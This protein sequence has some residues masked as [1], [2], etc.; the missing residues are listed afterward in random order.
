[1][2]GIKDVAKRAGVSISTVSNVLNQTKYVSPELVKRVEDAVQEL[3]YEVDPIARSM[4]SNKSGTIGVIV[5][6]MCGVF[7]PYVVKG[8][9][10][11]AVEKGYQIIIG[12][13]QGVYGDV[14]AARREKELFKRL[15]ASRVDGILFVTM[16]HQ[17]LMEKHFNEILSRSSQSKRIPL[18]SLERDLTSI[19]IDSVYFDSY[20]NA[21]MA[22]QHLIDCGCRKIGHIT[23][24]TTLQIA[25]DRIQGYKDC[26][27][28]NHLP[29]DWTRQIE[30]GDYTHQSGYL[31]VKKLLEDMPDL[32]G[33]FCSNDQMAVGALK[34]LKE[35]GKRVPEDIKVMGYDDVFLSSI[36]EPSLSTIHIQKTHTGIKAAQMLFERIEQP[37]KNKEPV[38]LKMSARLVVRKSTVADTSEEWIFVDW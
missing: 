5:E 7:Y 29:A 28:E 23:G 32:D 11:V 36:I 16:I 15:F 21:K 22:V 12:D 2:S 34:L 10:S 33:V 13:A 24:P 26:I 37:E 18:V 9:N 27:E 8:I 30:Y 25:L 35:Y 38:G 31:A 4:K 3:S 20:N 17:D 14:N 19:G 1:M 6:D